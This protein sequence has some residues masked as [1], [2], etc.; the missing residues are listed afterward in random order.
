[1][2]R[3]HGIEAENLKFQNLNK[4]G[5]ALQAEGHMQRNTKVHLQENGT[6]HGE[7]SGPGEASIC[8]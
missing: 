2:T 7:D 6:R 8:G 4:A 1:M 5:I 3:K